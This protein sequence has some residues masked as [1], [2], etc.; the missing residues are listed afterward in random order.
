MLRQYQTKKM[1]R[2]PR[3]LIKQLMEIDTQTGGWYQLSMYK[4]PEPERWIKLFKW[5]SKTLGQTVNIDTHRVIL[6]RVYGDVETHRDGVAKTVYVIPITLPRTAVIKLH[7]DGRY[8]TV[9]KH[10]YYTI[11]DYNPHGVIAECRSK[12]VQS[13]AMYELLTVEVR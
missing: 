6:H 12:K 5:I 11:N 4:N 9:D 1:I 2:P 3:N 13:Y 8:L 10:H 7:E